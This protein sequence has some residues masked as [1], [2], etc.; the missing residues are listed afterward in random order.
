[1]HLWIGTSGFQYPE[2]KG[3]FFPE[4]LSTAKMLTYYAERLSSTEINST[5][6]SLPT[7]NT[8]SRWVAET[9]DKFRF[10]LK[11]PQ[12]VTH[13]AKMKDCAETMQVFANASAGL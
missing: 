3:K 5:F 10:S 9:P 12:K 13:F 8:V 2:W 11:A 1:M 6:R 4:K 7:A